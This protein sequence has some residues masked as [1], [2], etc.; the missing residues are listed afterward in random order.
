LVSVSLTEGPGGLGLST[1]LLS[2]PK[3][4]Q[5]RLCCFLSLFCITI[6]LGSLGYFHSVYVGSG[7][8]KQGLGA[9]CS[10]TLDWPFPVP[11]S[12]ILCHLLCG[13]CCFYSWNF[14]TIL[15]GNRKSQSREG[16]WFSA[17]SIAR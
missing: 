17:V 7:I 8:W 4:L 1:V 10:V 6:C 11:F 12:A 14:L 15:G 9:Q 2:G 13:S 16:P 5:A 3:K